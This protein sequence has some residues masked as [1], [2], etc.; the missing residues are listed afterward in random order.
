[1]NIRQGAQRPARMREPTQPQTCLKTLSQKQHSRPCSGHTSD[2]VPNTQTGQGVL[3]SSDFNREASLPAPP[4]SESEPSTLSDQ[5]RTHR[6]TRRSEFSLR[7]SAAP[8]PED[9]EDPL[10]DDSVLV[11]L[12]LSPPDSVGHRRRD[13]LGFP[14]VVE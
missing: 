6:G 13:T 11:N 7:V 9:S 1:M 8:S 12:N 10:N 14:L 5:S 4:E 3:S 2:P